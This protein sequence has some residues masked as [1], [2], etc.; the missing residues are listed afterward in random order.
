MSGELTLREERSG[1]EA[2][3]G[4]VL[5]SAFGGPL[6][7]ELVL[8]LRAANALELSLVAERARRQVEI[9]GHV[10][11]SPVTT[12]D[13]GA[14]ARG[15]GLAPLGVLPEE[16]RCGTG[17]ALSRRALEL[18]RASGAAFVVLL[19]A[20]AFYRRFG[21]V[22]AGSAG[23]RCV[24]DAPPEAF[25]VLELTPGTLARLHGRVLH[26]AAFARFE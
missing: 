21:F 12:P 17:S 10:A 23:L 19:G 7:A 26:S 4:R 15:F 3:I 14:L 6:E 18:A 1:D 9:V 16:Q 25:Q 2:A 24:Y 5:E 8:D 13:C 11:L 22:P 20:P